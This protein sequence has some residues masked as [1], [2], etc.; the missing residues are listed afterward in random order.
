MNKKYK[1]KYLKNPFEL[2]LSITKRGNIRGGG[3]TNLELLLA[4][5]ADEGPEVGVGLLMSLEVSLAGKLFVAGLT[6]VD[7]RLAANTTG[8]QD[9]GE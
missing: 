3:D 5:G 4:D 9:D 7:P 6:L 1:Y 8:A 2:G